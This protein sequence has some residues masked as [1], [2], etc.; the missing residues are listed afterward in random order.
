MTT[1]HIIVQMSAEVKSFQ[2]MSVVEYLFNSLYSKLH[3]HG[4]D[5][6]NLSDIE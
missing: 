4:I 5:S 2:F 3:K 6:D 1:T